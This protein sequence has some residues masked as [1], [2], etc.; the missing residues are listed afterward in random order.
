MWF[1]CILVLLFTSEG[2]TRRRRKTE[3]LSSTEVIKTS[4]DTYPQEKGSPPVSWLIL[5]NQ[6]HS[7]PLIIPLYN[8]LFINS[9]TLHLKQV[10]GE[11]SGR[12]A[13][14]H[15]PRGATHLLVVE[16]PP[17]LLSALGYLESALEWWNKLLLL[18]KNL[19]L[20][21]YSNICRA[22]KKLWKSTCHL[23]NQT[24]LKHT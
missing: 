20:R 9:L 22:V 3:V 21:H 7:G 5:P 10:C 19:H 4:Q 17:S 12:L 6:A 24:D 18:L 15:H 11:R 13:A 16:V 14:V 2:G 23:I 1:L 8:C